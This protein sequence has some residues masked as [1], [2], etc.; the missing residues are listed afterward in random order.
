VLPSVG[1]LAVVK[2][3]SLTPGGVGSVD[4]QFFYPPVDDGDDSS[5]DSISSFAQSY[6][7]S[8]KQGRSKF[9]LC[10]ITKEGAHYSAKIVA[11]DKI[12]IIPV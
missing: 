4:N 7:P 10:K 12:P 11:Y 3:Q 9:N 6:P 8:S 5:F 1:T 2:N